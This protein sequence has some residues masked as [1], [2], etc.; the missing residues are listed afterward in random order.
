MGLLLLPR[1]IHGVIAFPSQHPWLHFIHNIHG[2]I[3]FPSLHPW[4]HFIHNI[5][6][7]ITFPSLH[8]RSDIAMA[9][10]L[11]LDNSHGNISTERINFIHGPFSALRQ[12]H[13]ASDATGLLV[14]AGKV[15]YFHNPPSSET[16]HNIFNV[17]PFCIILYSHRGPRFTVSP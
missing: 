9:V 14:N 10:L 15:L 4:L 2:Y 12:T 11:F 13:W 16:D 7:Y 3:T 17:S 8:S 5:H 6:G 1:N